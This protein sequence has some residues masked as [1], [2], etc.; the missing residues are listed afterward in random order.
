MPSSRTDTCH[1]PEEMSSTRSSLYR[2]ADDDGRASPPPLARSRKSLRS[3]DSPINFYIQRALETPGLISLAAGLVDEESLPCSAVAQACQAVLADPRRGPAALQY[4]STQGLPRLREQ[5]LD[6]FCRAD[7]VSACE[8]HLSADDVILTT[9][10]QQLLYLLA[11]ALLDPGDIVITE[12]PSYFVFH[13]VLQSHGVEV[14]GVPIEEEGLSLPALQDLLEQLHRCGRLERLKLLYTVD[15]FQNPTGWTLSADRRPQLLELIQRYSRRHRILIVEDAAYRELRYEGPDLRS[16]KSYDHHNR[17]VVYTSTFSKPCAPGLKC[18]YALLPPDLRDAVL[19]LKG[20]HDFG[21]AHLMQHVVAE[22]IDRGEYQRQ[23]ERLR[24]VYR[25]KRDVMLAELQACFGSEQGVRWSRPTGGLYVW[26]SFADRDTGPQG[27]L[28]QAAWAE[29][30][31]Y[32]PGEFAY[33]PTS[34]ER[35]PHQSCRLSF[36]VAREEQIREG[37]R[38][39]HRAYRRTQAS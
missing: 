18:G 22:L 37:V 19:H 15:Y 20:N 21:S 29:G 2:A 34:G 35:P 16:I 6:V 13:S 27:P 1:R 7:A 31:L 3:T 26:L 39:L 14:V 33:L 10:S 4:G 28:A 30:V 17:F 38:R 32:V 5:V 23:V 12:A 11:E 36:G 24:P 8:L 25:H 9:G